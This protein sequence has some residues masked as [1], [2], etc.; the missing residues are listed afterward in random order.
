MKRIGELVSKYKVAILIVAIILIIPALINYKN[1][2]INYDILVYLPSNIETVK[3]EKILTEDFGLGAYSISVIDNMAP[4]DIVKLEKRIKEIPGVSKVGS[5]YDLIGTTIPKEMLPEEVQDKLYDK[6]STILF[7]TFDGA[8]SEEKTLKAVDEV[9]KVA[10]GVNVGGMSAIVLD[11]KNL[12]DK[13]MLTYIVLAVILCLIVL[14]IS[15][16][17]YIVP[18]LLLLNIGIAIIYNMGTNIFF[19]EIS[20]ITKAISAVLQLGVTTDFSIFLYHKYSELKKKYKDSNKAMSDAIAE[21]SKSVTGSSLT[22]IAGFLALCS[23]SLTLGKDIGLVMA[24]GVVFGVFCVL[25]VFPAILLTFD[26]RLSKYDHK[27]IMPSFDKLNYFIVK[28]YKKIFILFLIILIP[29]YIA[30]KKTEVYYNLEEGLPKTLGSIKS[31]RELEERFGIVSPEIIL[32]DSKLTNNDTD[33]LIKEIKQIEGIDFVLSYNDLEKAGINMD[34]LDEDISSNFK[35]DKYKLL[36]ANSIYFNATDELNDQIDRVIKTVK[37][38]DKNAI[39][40]GNGAL[41]KDLVKTSAVDFNNV[42]VTS[43]AV[44]FLLMFFVLGSISLPVILILTIELA[45]FI[46]MGIPYIFHQKIPFVASI[47][48]GTIQLGATIDYAILMT[49]KYLDK[50]KTKM[51]KMNSIM[52]AV[53]NSSQSIFTS[54][55]CF[56]SAT[57]GVGIISKLETIGTLCMMMARGSIISMIVV[58][59]VLPSLL[60]IFD[61]IIVKTTKCFKKGEIIKMK[62]KIATVILAAILVFPIN[63]F[64]LTKNETVYVKMNNEGKQ[65][66]YSVR[67][68]LVNEEKNDNIKLKTGLSNITNLNGNEKFSLNNSDLIWAAKG[69]DI[70]YEGTTE[71]KLPIGLDITYKLNGKKVNP[72]DIKGKK[73]NIETI[74]HFYNYEKHEDVYTPFVIALTTKLGEETRNIKVSNGTITSNGNNSLVAAISSPGLAESL[75]QKELN[76]LDEITLSYETKGF[77]IPSYYLMVTPKLLEKA[78]LN[79]LDN[80]D[81]IYQDISTLGNASKEIKNG[82]K[83]LKNGTSEFTSGMNQYNSAMKEIKSY[84]NMMNDSYTQINDGVGALNDAIEKIENFVNLFDEVNIDKDKYVETLT[85]I[86]QIVSSLEEDVDDLNLNYDNHIANLR[87]IASRIEDEEIRNEL[88]EEIDKLDTEESLNKLRELKQK[89]NKLD[90]KIDILLNNADL[91]VDNINNLHNNIELLSSSTKQLKDGSNKFKKGFNEFNGGINKATDASNQLYSASIQIKDGASTLSEGI[92]RFDNEGINRLVEI[93]NNQV[94][95]KV[96]KTQKLI[97]LSKS[98]QTYIDNEDKNITT[99]STIIILINSSK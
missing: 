7:V 76:K 42:S 91:I 16:D 93:V 45:I 55:L 54:A 21:T 64:A 41:T 50:R 97:N 32:I 65:N 87:E 86:K 30:N 99:N 20:Y 19:G 25:T 71:E 14:T 69:K 63:A 82:A 36:L 72:N 8:T 58:L 96:R 74:I 98:Y 24:K 28:H 34:L 52:Y 9:Q 29:A 73:G 18:I 47:V 12:S 38:Y 4:K 1:T 49:T 43:I 57:F 90:T 70:Y 2:K 92:D 51:D 59:L 5:I 27:P 75:N 22:T 3:G 78:D 95:T 23:M 56:F 89:I 11:T 79:M 85:I 67:E 44:V 83:K 15:L 94:K 88:L 68:H 48:L 13:E 37:K 33:K 17:N 31:Q 66:Y 46:N 6:D 61:N 35:N 40:A 84:S 81:S 62:T 60:I 53:N 26:K 80:M 39:V 10:K 77:K